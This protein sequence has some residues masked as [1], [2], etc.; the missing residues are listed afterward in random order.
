M[1]YSLIEL[2]DLEK[3][4][5][6]LEG[7]NLSTGFV[8]AILDLNGKVLYKSGWRDICTNFHRVNPE[9]SKRCTISD[10]ELA[11]KLIE[12][13]RY[14]FYKCLNGIV[15][16]GVP[17][18]INGEHIANLFS[19]QFFLEEPDYEFFRKQAREY[20]FDEKS[21]LEALA[22]IPVESKEKVL[23][24]V[25][26]LHNMTQLLIETAIRKLEQTELSRSLK[27]S[28]ERFQLLFNKAPLGYQ[29]LDFDGNFLEVNQQWLETLGYNKS[30]VIGRW[31]GDF[32]TPTYQ[33]GF[34]KRFPIFKEQGTIHSE[35]EMM[36][37]NGSVLFIAF[38]GRIGY[39]LNGE[40]KQTH[41]ILQDITERRQIEEKLIRSEKELQRVQ[42][43]THIGSW[44]LNIATNEVKWTE[45]LY[46]MYGFD[47]KLPVPPY[48]EHQK[49]F[50]PESW[51][52]LSKSLA[53]TAETGIPYELELKTVKKDGSNGWMWV[54]GETVT[55]SEGVTIGLW[56]AAQD[57]SHRKEM[58]EAVVRSNER[59]RSIFN[60]LQ[61][62]FFQADLKGNFTLISPSAASMFGYAS[63]EEMIGMSA[64]NLY[65]NESQRDYM[66]KELSEEMIIKDFI[67]EGRRKNGST[68]WVSMNV[69]YMYF[70]GKISGTE[71]VV[72]DISERKQAEE[73]LRKS[74]ENLAITLNSIGDA[75]ISTDIKG[76]IVQ[77][78][79]VAE[80][81]CGWRLQ[82]ALGK[83]LCE[84]FKI[85]NA[86]SRQFI[87]DPV[88]RVLEKGEIVGLANHTVLISRDGTEYQISDSAAPIKN[89][90]GEITGVVLVFSDVT[91]KYESERALKESEER[92]RALH[93]ASFGGIAIHD[94]GKILECNLGLSQIT[95]YSYEELLGM[96]GLLL[97]APDSRE[98]VLK[99]ILAGYEKPYEALG[100][101]KSG[102]LFP[103]RL[104]A[105]NIPYKQKNARTVEFRD[106][107]ESKQWEHLILKKTEEIEF[108][109]QRLE[110]LFEISQYQTN[111]IQEL[112]DFALNEAI[113]L[114]KSKIGY[115]YFYNEVDK[116]FVLNTWSNDVMQ[117][118]K[119]MNPQTIYELD[120][121][122]C[123][124]E[125][126]RQRK[127]IIIN[128]YQ[129]DNSLKKGIP[130]GHVKLVKFLTIPVF[131]DDKIV[132]VAG[133]ANKECDYD[134]SDV[135]QL[136]LL[137]DSV[138]K[139]S[140]RIL[141]IK[142]LTIA[143]EKA[144]ESDR[145]KSAFLANMS[146]EI[147]TPMN[148][149][150]GFAELLKVPGLSG[151]EQLD[152]IRI[153]EKSGSHML[154]IINDIVDISKIEAGLMKNVI[155][156]FNL[157]EQIEYVYNFFKPE[158]EAKGI[159]LIFGNSLSSKD[160]ILKSDREKVY[161]VLSNLVKNAIKYTNEGSIEFGY[162]KK[163]DNLEFYV[164]DTGIG[165]PKEREEAIFERF[166]QADIDD[167]NVRQGA[168]LGLAIAKSY[169]QML[170]GIIW[171]ESKVGV[172]STFYF[173]I[174]FS[175]DSL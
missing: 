35:F 93:N 162:S 125:A 154:K 119:V 101:R 146:H 85:I 171:V 98:V 28:E 40:F 15:D 110:S 158:A 71:G 81:L 170:G 104:E 95:G 128:D 166:I 58:E 7:F 3:I 14:H 109:N 137:M 24:I 20:G 75:V 1:K 131:S 30:E 16:V 77:M 8:T 42:E 29:S 44:Y 129:A 135:R 5:N 13:E 12:G 173:T 153:I 54:R 19:G 11:G 45:E 123:W 22:K 106:I 34:R 165:I 99:N 25:E 120:K 118:C 139:I 9:T 100:L 160:I 157:N 76:F 111:S 92:Y 105:R 134:N 159:K 68:F 174:P 38:D 36:H 96:D 21:Y 138:W 133:V 78:N 103:L 168:G 152:Y 60:N 47:P 148:G 116:H 39:D 51:E 151:E 112:L 50:T 72:R 64:F 69:Q 167:I 65:A 141:L 113:K 41:C 102:E 87:E 91:E 46:K 49:L 94:K 32:L 115:I 127:P 33:D 169:I 89:K 140:E 2:L 10:T 145:L 88:R 136:T 117:E 86:E 55:D 66:L 80:K 67:T 18:V 82:D 175:S 147:R 84:V 124:G 23:V 73:D 37:K 155:Q 90:K 114:T 48:T 132:A 150:L 149:I 27:E 142:D 130:Q 17:I 57:I 144:E 62:A 74:E 156:E 172:G 79:P 26:F 6:L 161:A 63:T 164:K 83:P 107:T 108:N 53:H 121:T 4:D 122:G 61:D 70:N 59:F 52:I 31:F 43:I 143:K 126:V 97:I 163:A 56:G